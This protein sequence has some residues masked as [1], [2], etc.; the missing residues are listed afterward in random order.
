M[1]TESHICTQKQTPTHA[2]VRAHDTNSDKEYAHKDSTCE[3]GKIIY[4]LI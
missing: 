3:S 4:P 2:H 1:C